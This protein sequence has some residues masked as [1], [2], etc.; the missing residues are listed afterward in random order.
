MPGK[1]LSFHL[2]E[3][4]VD[5]LLRAIRKYLPD[6]VT[7]MVVGAFLGQIGII[8]TSLVGSSPVFL[9]T[10]ML[11]LSVGIAMA[12]AALRI[13]PSAL[14]RVAGYPFARMGMNLVLLA[15]TW[16]IPQALQLAFSTTCDLFLPL[17]TAA[18]TDIVAGSFDML[19][20]MLMPGFVIGCFSALAFMWL[21]CQQCAFDTQNALSAS[22]FQSSA[23][24]GLASKLVMICVGGCSLLVHSLIA[25]PMAATV[26]VLIVLS[27]CLYLMDR[28]TATGTFANEKQKARM[29]PCIAR[30]SME[31]QQIWILAIHA[32]VGGMA[33][34]AAV[35]ILA[36]LITLSWPMILLSSLTCSLCL[37]LY[38]R[39]I[40]LRMIP[41]Y[42]LNVV[43][44]L[45]L[46]TLS[47]FMPSLLDLNLSMK[48]LAGWIVPLVGIQTLQ[49]S[50]VL[51]VTAW[52]SFG[53]VICRA[54]GCNNS[55]DGIADSTRGFQLNPPEQYL[56]FLWS[57]GCAFAWALTDNGIDS[58][59]LLAGSVMLFG[60]LQAWLTWRESPARGLRSNWAALSLLL[61]GA[62]GPVFNACVRDDSATAS[63]LMFSERTMTAVNLGLD[64][65]L[66][67]H[68][69]ASRLI[70]RVTT[71]QGEVQVWRRSAQIL[72]FRRNGRLLGQVSSD[73]ELAPQPIEDILP[74]VLPLVVHKQPNRILLVGD[75]T[76]T[77]L[78]ICSHFPVQRIVAVREGRAFT[79]LAS[80][81]TWQRNDSGLESDP[82]I[83][84]RHA[85]TSIAL[86]QSP[87][88]PFDIMIAA[89]PGTLTPEQAFEFNNQFYQ[90]ARSQV[91]NEGVFC[92]RLQVGHLG[93]ETIRQVLSTA[94]SVFDHVI[95]IQTI[96]GE[97]AVLC[98]SVEGG[99][100]GEHILQR[101]QRDFVRS[102]IAVAGWDWS[103]VAILPMLDC[104]DPV[105]LFGNGIGSSVFVAANGNS[106]LRLPLELQSRRDWQYEMQQAF[107][108]YQV[109]LGEAVPMGE[110]Q[111]EVKRRLTALSQQVEILAGMPD[112]PWTYRRS[113][114][115][116]MQRSPRPPRE[117][118]A[119][120]KVQR[121]KHPTDKLHQD[122][123]FTLGESLQRVLHGD[124]RF[125]AF[126]GLAEFTRQYEPLVSLF[127]HYE[128]VRLH[129]LAEHPEPVDEFRHRLHT[130]YFTELSDASVRPVVA[131]LQ[132][133]VDQPEL[134]SADPDRYD[135]L[136][137]LVQK[138]I[139]RWEARTA[140]EPRSAIRVQNDV[141]QSVRATN[142][143]MDLMEELSMTAGISR[144]DFLRR[145]R[146]INLAL[147]TPLRDYRDQVL[148]H[149][150]K[151]A[152]AIETGGED[153]DD[154][155]LL[156]NPAG[157][158]TA[159]EIPTN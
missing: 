86:N 18:S 124:K 83:T 79:A 116:E 77:C 74:A 8:W 140:W 126:A 37:W 130:V 72:E 103:Q 136:N 107:G 41:P 93:P 24:L 128:L 144:D 142:R 36:R 119:N 52:I 1:S 108:A 9:T 123:F 135:Q 13:A 3:S 5:R 20:A 118:I 70:T 15:A 97:L 30:E 32:V 82:R 101:L 137:A 43:A 78:R 139:E 47:L 49:V 146:F 112:E 58:A 35:S 56:L 2:I 11:G 39:R 89:Q 147:V 16:L 57:I 14:V 158:S 117:I 40:V 156:I 81:Y 25:M 98:S 114:R 26:S 60:M 113:L 7:C 120:G 92:Q 45:S 53:A 153:P 87:E 145:R 63:R 94:R 44:I 96:P 12:F 102:E 6:G 31:Q 46:G 71:G 99:M 110:A 66:L 75:D 133:L 38:S 132:Q 105:G 27:A 68:S 62:M 90:S 159:E 127:A 106:A 152:K 155:P 73:A 154:L 59:S 76:G 65:E 131:A 21:S 129:E 138:L 34:V 69:D 122:Y 80:K 134:I 4:P 28:F 42:G 51:V 61:V 157:G 95:A 29:E 67:P 125:E 19:I 115:V 143:A 149:R 10:L 100:L 109:R 54:S 151:N 23:C 85:A 33:C 17:T 64:E 55:L 48:S 22:K 111:H 50:F 104:N 148:A 141:E 150:M 91:G 84:I 121:I 88:V